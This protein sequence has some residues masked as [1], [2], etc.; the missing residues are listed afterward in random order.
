MPSPSPLSQCTQ[1]RYARRHVNAKQTPR[2]KCCSRAVDPNAP[3][4]RYAEAVNAHPKGKKENA[5]VGI[6]VLYC[7]TKNNEAERRWSRPW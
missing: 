5:I 1:Y 4:R 2:S 6:V 7:L 3:C